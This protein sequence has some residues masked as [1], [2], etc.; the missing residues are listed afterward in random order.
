MN[1]EIIYK[2]VTHLATKR[3][4]S[5][6]YSIRIAFYE[7]NI[8]VADIT[9][10]KRGCAN[11]I[12]G[13]DY[14]RSSRVSFDECKVESMYD[15]FD[16]LHGLDKDKVARRWFIREMRYC[17]KD[18]LTPDGRFNREQA[19]AAENK[20]FHRSHLE[21]PK[22]TVEM[23][24]SLKPLCEEAL[25]GSFHQLIRIS[26]PEWEIKYSPKTLQSPMFIRKVLN[27]RKETPIVLPTDVL[28]EW[29]KNLFP[30]FYQEIE[31]N[32]KMDS[33]QVLIRYRWLEHEYPS[34]E[35]TVMDC[36]YIIYTIRWNRETL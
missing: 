31:Q 35:I 20:I 16:C 32:R 15:H 2:S 24:K 21:I 10:K 3:F 18:F 22:M 34:M 25:C 1:S 19:K 26:S 11:T 14:L 27:R 7:H 29:I 13:R 8:A 6:H 5:K 17:T 4:S 28:L 36:N 9:Y 12:D 33:C 23:L 30:A